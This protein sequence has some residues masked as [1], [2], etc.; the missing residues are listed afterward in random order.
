MSSAFKGYAITFF[1]MED[2]GFGCLGH[3]ER[4][5]QYI[6]SL[7]FDP[8]AGSVYSF[9]E[10]GV[11]LESTGW[12]QCLTVPLVEEYDEEMKNGWDGRL[13]EAAADP[14]WCRERLV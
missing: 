12:H 5:T 3:E 2:I 13:A 1:Q 9:D 11:H 14:Q 10:S 7:P 8:L 4:S 6:F